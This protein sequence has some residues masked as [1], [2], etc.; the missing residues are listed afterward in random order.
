MSRSVLLFGAVLILTA[1][2][3]SI[4]PPKAEHTTVRDTLYDTA[5]QHYTT[6]DTTTDSFI[7]RLTQSTDR[8]PCAAWVVGTHDIWVVGDSL[9]HFDGTSWISLIPNVF[10]KQGTTSKLFRNENGMLWI[11]NGEVISYDPILNSSKLF[12]A[13][14]F[15]GGSIS[16][17]WGK[18][19]NDMFFVGKKGLIAHFDG[20]EFSR[21]VLDT[22]WEFTAITGSSDN[23]IWAVGID[24]NQPWAAIAA[25]F[26]GF[27]WQRDTLSNLMGQV[28]PPKTILTI[29]SAG[30]NIQTMWTE[31]ISGPNHVWRKTDRAAW[32]S[33]TLIDAVG[34]FLIGTSFN[35]LIA[36]GGYY[37][38]HWN[39]K[40]WKRFQGPFRGP[41]INGGFMHEN[42]VCIVEPPFIYVG[43]R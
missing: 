17:A 22:S 34:G 30:H 10:A 25:H 2:S 18:S 6:V 4:S 20:V 21:I 40:F 9:E 19:N 23:D 35:D 13:K 16:A 11:V 38:P 3:Q 8:F 24:H 14:D 41:A 32:R 42:T 1:C 36:C 26:D 7:W 5:V 29:D 12:H 33:D 15:G 43:Y 27:L 31:D 28:Y 39:G 37:W